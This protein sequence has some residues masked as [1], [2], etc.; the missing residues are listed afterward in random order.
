MWDMATG[1]GKMMLK[2]HEG[3]VFDCAISAD[4]SFIASCS[5]DKTVRVW[6][7][8]KGELKMTLEGHKGEVIGCAIS[9]DRALSSC[10]HTTR[11]C[12]CG[13]WRRAR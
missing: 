9:A 3:S 8:A 11:R 13:T 12:S 6:D 2:G 4:G 1:K 10:A 5:Q 7:V